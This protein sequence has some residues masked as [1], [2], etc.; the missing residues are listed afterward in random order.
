MEK[1]VIINKGLL[2]YEGFIVFTSLN[3]RVLVD[4][5]VIHVMVDLEQ[6][7]IVPVIDILTYN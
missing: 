3:D 1:V 7:I 5:D 4:T 2:I 6:F